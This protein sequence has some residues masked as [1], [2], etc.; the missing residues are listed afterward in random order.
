MTLSTKFNLTF[1]IAFIVGLI[2]AAILA[3]QLARANAEAEVLEKARIMMETAQAIR[4]YTLEEIRPLLKQ[5]E[6]DRFRAGVRGVA[7]FAAQTTFQALHEEFPDYR[8]KEAAINPTN[9]AD[10]ATDWEERIIMMFRNNPSTEPHTEIRNAPSGQHLI[11]AQ[12]LQLTDGGCLECH[13]RVEDAPPAM[14]AIYGTT[15]GFGWEMGEVV[16]AQIVSVPMT[17]ALE[18]ARDIFLG[19]M[20]ILTAVFAVVVVVVNIMLR[21]TVIRPIM[22]ISRAAS[23]VSMGKMDVPEI[24]LKGKDEIASLSMSFNRMRR[25]LESALKMLND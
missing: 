10:R 23:D 25:S 9:L 19:Y 16:A 3:W 18:R 1:L 17:V 8:Y 22:A 11:L 13:G 7:A 21:M 2:S 24:E 4:Q 5:V 12:P 14:V 6:D 20:A 15:N